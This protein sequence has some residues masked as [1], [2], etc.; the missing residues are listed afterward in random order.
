MAD[1]DGW[2]LPGTRRDG[3]SVTPRWEPVPDVPIDGV[4]FRLVANVLSGYGR[5]TELHRS[6]WDDE[7]VDQVFQSEL[8]PGAVSAW[9]AHG[10]TLDRLACSVGRLRIVTFDAR[11]ASPTFGAVNAFTLGEH[12][13]GIVRVPAQVWHGV[14][15]VGDR[16]AVLVNAVDRAYRYDA[17][18]HYRVPADSPHIPYDILGAS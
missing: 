10:V 8:R 12:R 9:H 17:P 13:P 1:D 4:S 2:Q 16:P 3:Q 7:P 18:D 5:I 6:E 11:P 15:N 14:K